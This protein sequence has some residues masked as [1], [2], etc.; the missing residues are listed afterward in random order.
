MSVLILHGWKGSG[1]EHW[2]SWLKKELDKENVKVLYPELPNNEYPDLFLWISEVVKIFNNHKIQTV[3]CHSLA[4]LFW[5][6]LLT[7]HPKLFCE[8]LLLV[9]PPRW[10]KKINK[11]SSFYPPPPVIDI[12]NNSQEILLVLSDNDPYCPP[13]DA[14]KIEKCLNVPTKW[15][16]GVGHI[17]EDAGFGPWPFAK[18]W[19]LQ[20]NL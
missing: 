1:P 7:H 15:L 17:N 9:A 19:V 14:K 6:H 12:K 18:E 13:H 5:F 11:A 20:Y 8:N 2:Q 4:N 3:V 10:S 16:S